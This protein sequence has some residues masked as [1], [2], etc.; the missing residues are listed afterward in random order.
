MSQRRICTFL[1]SVRCSP[2]GLIFG[3][4]GVLEMQYASL[5]LS[6][7]TERVCSAY[8]FIITVGAKCYDCSDVFSRL[9][10]RW[11]V[12]TGSRHAE[13]YGLVGPSGRTTPQPSSFSVRRWSGTSTGRICTGVGLHFHGLHLCVGRS[14]LQTQVHPHTPGSRG[15]GS[16]GVIWHH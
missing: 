12:G 16:P 5:V 1:H 2:F 4:G 6:S 14:A 3:T 8:S 10:S 11:H 7:A 13:Q 15:V 9:V